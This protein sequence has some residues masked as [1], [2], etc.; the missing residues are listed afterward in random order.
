[1]KNK[2][3]QIMGPDNTPL[4]TADVLVAVLGSQRWGEGVT[5]NQMHERFQ[6]LD[7]LQS[8]NGT[9]E[10]SSEQW[11]AVRNRYNAHEFGV[12]HRDIYELGKAINK[13]AEDAENAKNST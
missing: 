4:T 3:L 13:L 11:E 7:V 2:E 10:L 1:M 9:I 8:A 12:L 5:Y 6:I